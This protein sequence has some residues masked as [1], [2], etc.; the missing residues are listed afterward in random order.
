[1][2]LKQTG[3]EVTLDDD[4][5]SVFNTISVV[6]R[7]LML[8]GVP[9]DVATEYTEAALHCHSYDDLLRVTQETVKVT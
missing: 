5:R 7:A 4:D 9:A 6:R 1:M 3:V 8:A 2:A